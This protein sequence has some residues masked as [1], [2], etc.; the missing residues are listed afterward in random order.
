ML[1][2]T[3]RRMN[4]FIHSLFLS[5]NQAEGGVTQSHT[6]KPNIKSTILVS[7]SSS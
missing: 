2:H 5:V 4:A 7:D 3:N 1:A 6:S